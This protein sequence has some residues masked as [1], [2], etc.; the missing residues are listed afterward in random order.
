MSEENKVLLRR[1]L[2]EVWNGGR[3]DLIDELVDPQYLSHVVHAPPVSNRKELKRW[4]SDVRTA[5]PD[6]R[7]MIEDLLADDDKTILRWTSEASH[8]GEFL[9]ISG[10]GKRVVCRGISISRFVGGKIVEEWGEWDA[11]R[12]MEQIGGTPK[13]AAGNL[14]LNS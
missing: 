12:L 8:D 14:N 9:G 3:L 13:Q 5:F 7:F 11:L 6:I 2:T 4:V 1:Y 10:T